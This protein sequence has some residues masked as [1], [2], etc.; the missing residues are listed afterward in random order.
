MKRRVYPTCTAAANPLKSGGRGPASSLLHRLSENCFQRNTKGSKH[1]IAILVVWSDHGFHHGEKGRWGKHTLWER[2]SH[3][4]FIWAGKGVARG[5]KV[6]A[7][8]SLIDMYPTF[9]DLC[10]LPKV[11]GLE[12]VSL[13]PVLLDPASAVD[14]N[15]LLPHMERGAYAVI[16][17]DWRYIRYADGGEELYDVRKDPHEWVNLAGEERL[18]AVKAKLR[19]SAPKSFASPV[20]PRSDL[21][22]IVEGDGFRWERK[23]R[24]AAGDRK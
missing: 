15:V 3:V 7:T 20:T 22:L 17:R 5:A 11:E 4:P 16:N 10:S 23:G 8:V 2:T 21:R 24:G 14:R 9:I 19:A 18:A 12:G 1:E 6:D 13:A